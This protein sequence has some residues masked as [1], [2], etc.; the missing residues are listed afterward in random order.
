M[1]KRGI[2]LF[3][4]SVLFVAITFQQA[5]ALKCWRCSSDASTSAF[6]DDPFDPSI[7]N[8]QQRRWAYVDCSFPATGQSPY[9]Q[10]GSSS[11]RPVCKK[12]KQLINDKVVI[13]RSC[14]WEDINAPPDSCMRTTTPSYIKTEFCETCGHDGCNSA[15][16]FTAATVLALIPAIFAF[17]LAL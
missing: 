15:T 5:E 17:I 8:D 3:G 7:I 6:C 13:S 1:A 9:G 16:K 14:S 2:L 4:A 11:S 10:Y 12:M